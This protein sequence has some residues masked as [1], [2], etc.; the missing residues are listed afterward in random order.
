MVYNWLKKLQN[1]LFPPRCLLCNADSKTEF[2]LC[3]GCCDDLPFQLHT[4]PRC[5]LPLQ[6]NQLCGTC[7]KKPPAYTHCIAPFNYAPPLDYMIQ[8]VKYSK[9]LAYARLLGE[10][11]S[12]QFNQPKIT[13][14]DII[15]PVPLHPKRIRE[16]GFNQSLELVRPIAKSL[17]IPIDYHS[18]QRIRHTPKQA[19]LTAT[20]RHEN[21]KN[22]F[23]IS[24][25]IDASHVAL[26]DDVM[27]TG[28]TVELLAKE[29]ITSGVERVDVWVC[30]RA[31]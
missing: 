2:D 28:T 31:G 4:C 1:N 17:N 21:L 29:L 9:K 26:F 27:T 19:D 8:Q 13:K 23:Q 20:Q 18:C 16:R 10:L 7:Q 22:A 5:A 14:P 15:I 30:A 6:M 3:L 12:H 11:M 24:K 25:E